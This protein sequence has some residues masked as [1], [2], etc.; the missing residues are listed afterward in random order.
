MD[1]PLFDKGAFAFARLVPQN[2]RDAHE[3]IHVDL[4]AELAAVV[5]LVATPS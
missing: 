2:A 4:K 3:N 1:R 5:A